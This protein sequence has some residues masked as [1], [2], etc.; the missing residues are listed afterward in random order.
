MLKIEVTEGNFSG[1]PKSKQL[2]AL[3][4]ESIPIICKTRGYEYKNILCYRFLRAPLYLKYEIVNEIYHIHR[5]SQD[6]INEI[7]SFF[8]RYITEERADK[9]TVDFTKLVDDAIAIR[10]HHV[11]NHSFYGALP[12]QSSGEKQPF[13]IVR[14]VEVVGVC[15]GGVHTNRYK[16]QDTFFDKYED[17][18]KAINVNLY[19]KRLCEF[20]TSEHLIDEYKEF[21]TYK[22]YLEYQLKTVKLADPV[23]LVVFDSKIIKDSPKTLVEDLLT[24]DEIVAA[25]PKAVTIIPVEEKPKIVVAEKKIKKPVRMQVWMNTYGKSGCAECPFCKTEISMFQFECGH[26]VSAANGGETIVE[27]LSPIC[28]TCNKSMGATNWNDYCDAIG[29]PWAK[30]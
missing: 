28:S 3:L 5:Y 6:E 13:K 21:V 18:E 25:K 10:S 17:A 26:I 30:L 11:I 2:L 29:M 20:C 1:P 24:F 9:I 19:E 15:V 22:R 14:P 12:V 7:F 4:K 16:V 23:D 8:S 27:N